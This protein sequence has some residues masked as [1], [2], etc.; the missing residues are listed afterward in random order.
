[1]RGL[2]AASMR[3]RVSHDTERMPPPHHKRV[4]VRRVECWLRGRLIVSWWFCGQS[5]QYIIWKNLIMKNLPT[6]HIEE[7]SVDI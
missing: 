6:T 2:K 4:R 7:G 1:M 5:K 3:V